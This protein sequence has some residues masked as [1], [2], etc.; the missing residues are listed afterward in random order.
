MAISFSDSDF[1]SL[2]CSLSP[3]TLTETAIH[4]D[5][6]TALASDRGCS[7]WKGILTRAGFWQEL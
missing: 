5:P 1:E 4:K 6:M 3:Y 2:I 7:L